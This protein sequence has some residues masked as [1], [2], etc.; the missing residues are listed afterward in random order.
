MYLFILISYIYIYIYITIY[1]INILIIFN[2]ILNR[3]ATIKNIPKARKECEE[4]GSFFNDKEISNFLKT[5]NLQKDV[6]E[7]EKNSLPLASTCVS[8]ATSS[9]LQYALFLE[10]DQFIAFDALRLIAELIIQNDKH[11]GLYYLCDSY[12]RNR[13]FFPPHNLKDTDFINSM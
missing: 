6:I 8:N 11:V 13:K 7:C 5:I 1:D 10:D 3:K 4:K 9:S 2:F 12:F